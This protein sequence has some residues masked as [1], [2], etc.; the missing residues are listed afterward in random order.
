MSQ[1]YV[2]ITGSNVPGNVPT[3]FVANSGTAVPVVNV[4]NILASSTIA[5]N[6]NGITTIASGNTVTIDLTNRGYGTVTTTNA[7]PTTIITFPLGAVAGLYTI[8]GTVGGFIPA[9][10]A[11]GS[12][13]FFASVKTTGVTAT[14]IGVDYD[15]QIEDVVMAPSDINVAVSG[16]NV[17]VQVQGLAGTTINWVAEFLYTVV[18]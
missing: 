8:Q 7:T 3:S 16:N 10:N 2:P 11:G 12:Y 14:E 4:L 17:L 18:N 5:N 13:D 6:A 9:S 1:I 15:T